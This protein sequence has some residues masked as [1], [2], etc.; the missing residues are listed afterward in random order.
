LAGSQTTL[1]ETEAR[2]LVAKAPVSFIEATV[3]FIE[4]TVFLGE[5]ALTESRTTV[6]LGGATLTVNA[7]A[8]LE[9]LQDSRRPAGLAVNGRQEDRSDF[10]EEISLPPP[11]PRSVPPPLSR[12]GRPLESRLSEARQMH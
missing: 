2:V 6:F 1:T 5:T 11:Q 7:A 4:A 9:L 12:C 3:F 8:I 10:R